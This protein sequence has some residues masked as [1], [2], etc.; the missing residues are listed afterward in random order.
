MIDWLRGRTP[1]Y[2]SQTTSTK[3]VTADWDNGKNAAF[4]K[5]YDGTFSNGLA[6]TGVEGL[7]TIMPNSAISEWYDYSRSNGIRQSQAGTH[8]PASLS[9]SITQNVSAAQHGGAAPPS[10][11]ASCA[12][13]PR[14]AMSAVDGDADGNINQ[15]WQDR[16][17]QQQRQQ[18]PR[19][20]VRLARAERRQR[21][22]RPVLEVVDRPRGEQRAAQALA[23]P[24][25]PRRPVRLPPRHRAKDDGGWVDT[26]HQWFDYWLYGSTT[27]S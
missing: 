4:G 15:F 7:T 17:L 27:G 19:V 1:G 22:A 2:N 13:A 23:L 6:A 11:N 24:G 14:P 9:N 8:Y 20:G 10:N 5:S 26:I 16:E 3:P 18:R 12:A 25:G 21:Q